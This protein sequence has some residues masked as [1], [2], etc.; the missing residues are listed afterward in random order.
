MT[1]HRA[2]LEMIAH[3]ENMEALVVHARSLTD[4]PQAQCLAHMLAGVV[5]SDWRRLRTAQ[6]RRHAASQPTG[7]KLPLD[8]RDGISR[9]TKPFEQCSKRVDNSRI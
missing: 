8:D 3:V 4:D 1:N 6:R 2:M 5:A 9:G 7:Q